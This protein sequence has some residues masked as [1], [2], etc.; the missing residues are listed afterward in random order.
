MRNRSG[1]AVALA[2]LLLSSGACRGK[3]HRT[4]VQNDESEGGPQIAAVVRTNDPATS[5]QLLSG[6]YGVEGGAWRWTAGKF[7]V[8][9]RSPLGGAQ[10]G[11]TLHFAFTI[12]DVAIEKL[13]TIT[14]TASAG[15]TKLKSES[16][17]KPGP[18]TFTADVPA[19][20]LAADSIRVD[21]ELDKSIPA[22]AV[23]QRELGVIAAAISIEAQ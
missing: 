8:L 21:F 20:M 6:F 23:D 13:K 19:R 1:C 2:V 18:Y 9:L 12:P 14:L 3:H 16:Y 10:R 15:G 11:A 4:T 7:S 22:G 5:A 17:S